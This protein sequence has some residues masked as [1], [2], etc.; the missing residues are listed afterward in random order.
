MSRKDTPKRQLCHRIKVWIWG[1]MATVHLNKNKSPQIFIKNLTNLSKLRNVL[2]LILGPEEFNFK[3]SKD[4]LIFNMHDCTSHYKV[5]EYLTKTNLSFHTFT[6]RQ[7][8][9]TQAVIRHLCHSIPAEDIEAA[10]TELGF[11]VLSV[12]PFL[13]RV[14]QSPLSLF[15]VSLE[16]IES[17]HN[18]F[19]LTKLLNSTITVK[20]PRKSRFPPQ[21]M[22]CQLYSH[23][24]SYCRHTPRCVK[25]SETHLTADC[26]KSWNYLR[27]VLYVLEP[28]RQ[29][30]K[31]A[32]PTKNSLS[33]KI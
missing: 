2:S 19:K 5:V 18:I 1:I 32:L 25:C 24:R 33:S 17:S 27:N 6:L 10:L 28:I 26:T 30:I 21:S 12:H 22:K 8:Y 11:P 7:D 15:S 13:N 14:T 23:T 20:K 3:L 16:P 29:I 4:F 31:A 9:P